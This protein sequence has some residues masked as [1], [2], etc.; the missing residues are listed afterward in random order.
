MVERH[1]QYMYCLA[2]IEQGAALQNNTSPLS[3]WVYTFTDDRA[4]VSGYDHRVPLYGKLIDAV[5]QGKR[6][7]PDSF[8]NSIPPRKDLGAIDGPM[9]SSTVFMDYVAQRRHQ[10]YYFDVVAPLRQDFLSWAE[11]A[12][13]PNYL[14]REISLSVSLRR[15]ELEECRKTGATPTNFD[16]F[17]FHEAKMCFSASPRPRSMTQMVIFGLFFL[18][19]DVYVSTHNALHS[20]HP[21]GRV[22]SV[23]GTERGPVCPQAFGVPCMVRSSSQMN[24]TVMALSSGEQATKSINSRAAQ[25]SLGRHSRVDQLAL[26]RS[27]VLISSTLDW[28]MVMVSMISFNRKLCSTTSCAPLPNDERTWAKNIKFRE[29]IGYRTICSGIAN[30]AKKSIAGRDEGQNLTN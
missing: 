22:K 19:Q 9:E 15:Q 11:P 16:I 1:E 3:G 25:S 2:A 8:S 27:T 6:R 14:P 10:W 23:G 5:H 21:H 17:R 4:V 18:G 30:T 26:G 24:S 20:A 12:L 28:K 13:I 7:P 29:N